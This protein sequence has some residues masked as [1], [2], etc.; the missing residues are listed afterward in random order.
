L[1]REGENGRGQA[2]KGARWSCAWLVCFL[3]STSP[4]CAAPFPV[5]TWFGTGEPHDKG[6]MWIAHMLPNGEFRA[7][8]RACVKGKP[9][10]QTNTGQWVLTGDTETISVITVDGLFSPRTDI[11]KILF[12]DGKKQTYRYVETGFVFN[13][14]RVDDKFQM[15]SCESIS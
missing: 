2:S 3:A 13:S 12:Q 8:F 11:Y 1:A 7:E 14:R 10:D 4:L 5:G 6:E 15:P 9:L